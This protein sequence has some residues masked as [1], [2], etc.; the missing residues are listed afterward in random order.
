MMEREKYFELISEFEIYF[1]E[2]IK[3]RFKEYVD[4]SL[5][6]NIHFAPDI[7]SHDLIQELIEGD[8]FEVY[9]M[10]VNMDG[11]Q[12]LLD[13][14]HD[15]QKIENFIFTRLAVDFKNDGNYSV[16]I[17]NDSFDNE[18]TANLEDAFHRYRDMTEDDFEKLLHDIKKTHLML[19]LKRD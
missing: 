13:F 12:L 1:A 14:K 7:Q 10:N 16:Y 3:K 18:W 17:G 9:G 6:S 8:G 2:I 4:E 5:E 11:F 19:L 15:F